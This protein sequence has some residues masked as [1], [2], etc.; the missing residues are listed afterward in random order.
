MVNNRQRVAMV[1]SLVIIGFTLMFLVGVVWR[2][3]SRTTSTPLFTYSEPLARY[4]YSQEKWVYDQVKYIG[5]YVTNKTP[6]ILL[7][8]VVPLVL[9]TTA[10]YIALGAK[11]V[12]A[13]AAPAEI[14]LK[15]A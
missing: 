3:A 4:D 12:D 1:V 8:I 7:G 14:E 10:I 13:P 6:D 11:K 9:W 15:D 5:L 2:D